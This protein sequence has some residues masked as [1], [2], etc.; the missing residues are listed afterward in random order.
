MT[1]DLKIRDKKLK[2]NSYKEPKKILALSLG[3]S[4]EYEYLRR[5]EILLFDQNKLIE[6]A[7]FTYSLLV[8]T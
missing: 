2:Y 6:Q 7:R 4:D 3:K 8:E 5:E 1:M